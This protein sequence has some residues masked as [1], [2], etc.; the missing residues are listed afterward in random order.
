LLGIGSSN[1]PDKR[2]LKHL[3][4][5][6]QLG[7]LTPWTEAIG[8]TSKGVQIM[9]L[10]DYRVEIEQLRARLAKKILMDE[11]EFE[12]DKVLTFFDDGYKN[13]AE[14]KAGQIQSLK[15]QIDSALK[16]AGE[17]A[18]YGPTNNLGI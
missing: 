13:G 11:S 16:N 14:R 2:A 8:P 6:T 7:I 3:Q 4:I 17:L 10:D 9:T 1:N 12:N 18:L 5:Q 15:N